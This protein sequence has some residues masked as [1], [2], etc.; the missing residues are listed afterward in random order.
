MILNDEDAQGGE[1]NDPRGEEFEMVV[2]AEHARQRGRI[3]GRIE[4]D[5]LHSLH[6]MSVVQLQEERRDRAFEL[7]QVLHE[8]VAGGP[9]A[10]GSAPE[11]LK[12]GHQLS[13]RP[14]RAVQPRDLLEE[15]QGGR[16]PGGAFR[17]Y[18]TKR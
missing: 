7:S 13:W 8:D 17:G 16:S 6:A 10:V 14:P 5:P 9:A 2:P 11:G 1:G 18:L 12:V 15:L 4:E 3:A